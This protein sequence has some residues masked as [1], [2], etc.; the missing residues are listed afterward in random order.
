MA[1]VAYEQRRIRTIRSTWVVLAVTVA[2]AA[3]I[4]AATAALIN[5]DPETGQRGAP[6]PLVDV[7][8]NLSS[9]L[10][11]VPV[12]VLAAMAFGGEYRFGLMR[13]TLTLFPRRTPVFLAK[14]CV[15]SVWMVV[16]AFLAALAMLGVAALFPNNL[17]YEPL[18]GDVWLLV[19]RSIAFCLGYGLIVFALVLLTRNQAL[20][21]IVPLI[22]ALVVETLLSG[23]LGSRIDWLDKALPMQAGAGFAAGND[24]ASN[25]AVFFGTAVVFLIVGWAVFKRRD[26]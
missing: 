26:A 1:I 11:L 2:L 4:A 21:I 13:Q 17:V 10:I 8:N 9:P 6:A 22:W 7:L 3:G 16:F 5:I 23:F 20:S 19:L 15:V 18:S 12:S 24:M 14:L 25:A